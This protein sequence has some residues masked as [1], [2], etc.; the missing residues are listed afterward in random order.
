MENAGKTPK[1]WFSRTEGKWGAVGIVLLVLA[2][3]VGG[4]FAL[5]FIIIALTNTLHTILLLAAVGGI[6]ALAINPQS[7]MAICLGYKMFFKFITGIFITI[8]PIMILKNHV[9]TLFDNLEIMSDHIGEVKGI[10]QGLKKKVTE[11]SETATFEMK[12]AQVAKEKG[13]VTTAEISHRAAMRRKKSVE[14]LTNMHNNLDG[15]LVIL[16]KMHA[17]CKIMALDTK[18]NVEMQEDEWKTI[19]KANSAMKSAMSVIGGGGDQRALFEETLEYMIE[20]VSMKTGEMRQMIDQ[21]SEFMNNIDLENAMMDDA[22]VK[23]LENF[24]KTTDS[25]VSTDDNGNQ[26]VLKDTDVNTK[27]S[28]TD[29]SKSI[30]N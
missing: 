28:L 6:L 26:S 25:W 4:Y 16:G 11:Y 29:L 30:F 2:L 1:S 8:D 5:P 7:R 3:C 10:Q 21:S 27:V 20:D 14:K 22:L 19:K 13:D 15:V 18:D 24:E 23:N 9:R 17:N 12:K